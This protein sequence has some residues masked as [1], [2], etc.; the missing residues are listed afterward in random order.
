MIS[1]ALLACGPTPVSSSAERCRQLGGS[2]RS[3]SG[4]TFVVEAC[5]YDRSFHNLH[6]R[7]AL[8][9]N[10]EGDHFDCY[11]DVEAMSSRSRFFAARVPPDGLIIANG[12]DAHVAEAI[13]GIRC[14]V[15]TVG[16]GDR[17]HL[18]HPPGAVR[19]GCHWG[20][21]GVT[22]GPSPNCSRPW[23]G[24][25]ISSTRPWPGGL[26]RPA[27][28]SRPRRRRPG[29]ISGSRAAP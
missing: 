26:C 17:V 21:S 24:I 14:R 10:I 6:P 23:P 27:G 12:L 7:V 1:Y 5:E 4:R 15:E 20:Q 18:E 16:V 25:T 9:T 13:R 29:T 8:I 22:A 11:K 19:G 28:W 3:G 2:S